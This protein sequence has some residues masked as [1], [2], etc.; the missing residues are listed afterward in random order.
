MPT[1]PGSESNPPVPYGG[2]LMFTQSWEDPACDLAA[3]AI[4]PGETIFAII[5]GCDNV[6]E[7][8]LDVLAAGIDVR[9]QL[10]R[11]LPV[12]LADFVR[13]RGPGDAENVIGISH[14]RLRKDQVRRRMLYQT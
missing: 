6:L 13:R 7:F 10:L 2:R 3:L 5:S 12:G 14:M 11:Q 9:M 4:Q 8:L 1:L